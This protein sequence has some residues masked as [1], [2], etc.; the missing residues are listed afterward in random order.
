MVPHFMIIKAGSM[1][2]QA[3][4]DLLEKFGAKWTWQPDIAYRQDGRFRI[5]KNPASLYLAGFL[6]LIRLSLPRD[7]S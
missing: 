4:F 5:T 7:P 2:P 3:S 6:L 1:G